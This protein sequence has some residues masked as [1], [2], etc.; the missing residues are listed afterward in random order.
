[1]AKK[2]AKKSP[3]TTPK[4]TSSKK[5]AAKPKAK[6]AAKTPKSK[7]PAKAAKP[8]K[9][10]AASKISGNKA[11]AKPAAKPAA[12]A[13]STSAVTQV[14]NALKS[15]AN[16]VSSAFSGVTGD[17]K[18]KVKTGSTDFA[19]VFTPLDDRLVIER[20]GVSNRTAGGLYIPDS[21]SDV[22]K[23]NRGTVLA[24]GPGH[25][26]KKG[27]LRPLDVRAGDTVIFSKWAG[28]EITLEGQEL[29]L[30]RE[31]DVVAIVNE[32]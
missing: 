15:V 24:V 12:K 21:V 20:A 22:E 5:P 32:E 1:M 4:K 10:G 25:R 29:V 16:K 14:A 7:A 28:S 27:Q 13:K 11:A 9:A 2:T 26:N 17:T 31:S 18:K 8:T 3:K 23:P 30:V 6:P 19:S